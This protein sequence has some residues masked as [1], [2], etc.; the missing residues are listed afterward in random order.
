MDERL[1]RSGIIGFATARGNP[2]FP[3][4]RYVEDEEDAGKCARCGLILYKAVHA[5]TAE[6]ERE[7]GVL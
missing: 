7:R 2:G 4:H 6:S 1:N 5:E 3:F